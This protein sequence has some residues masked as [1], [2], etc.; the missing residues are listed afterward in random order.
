MDNYLPRARGNGPTARDHDGRSLPRFF[1]VGDLS[2]GA[3]RDLPEAAAHH[4]AR[5]LRLTVGDAVT[6]FNGAGGES[7]ARISSIGKDHVS[8]RV[9]P[10]HS[11]E[12]E[13]SVRVVLLQGLSARERMDFTVQKAVE[14]GVAEIFPVE[15]RRSVMRLAEERAMRRVEHWQNLAVAACEQCGRNRVPEVHPVAALSDWLGTHS[16]VPGE[17]LILSTVAE[18]RLRELSAPQELLLLAGPEGGFAP[19]EL[20]IAQAC[21]FTAVR[22][23]PRVLRTETAALA[24]LAAIQALW[25]DL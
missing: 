17:R 11:R 13:P 7:D 25:G 2:Q 5:V 15:M 10:W 19:E 23:G 8:V 1:C 24:A 22:L 9:G 14:L 18:R 6:V 20:E 4:A 12:A 3:T 21:G 16:A